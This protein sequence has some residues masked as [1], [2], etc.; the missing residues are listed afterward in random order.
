VQFEHPAWI[1]VARLL[2]IGNI[3]AVWFAAQAAEPVHATIHAILAVLFGLGAQYLRRR[4]DTT[5]NADE[6]ERLGDL[7]EQLADLD[8]V[9]N[10]EGR[11][12]ELEERLDFTERALADVRSRPQRPLQE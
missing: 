5:A 9:Q 4:R 7:D 10:L 6:L 2:S 1:R 12:A 8:K 3:A 11:L